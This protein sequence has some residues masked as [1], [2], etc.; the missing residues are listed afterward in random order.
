VAAAQRIGND[1]VP[2]GNKQ[3]ANG[4]AIPYSFFLLHLNALKPA[5]CFT[6]ANFTKDDL[7]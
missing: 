2:V 1:L 6:A 7:I 5:K 3:N 4:Q